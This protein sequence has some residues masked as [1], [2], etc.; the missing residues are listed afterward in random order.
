MLVGGGTWGSLF[1]L[2]DVHVMGHVTAR[3]PSCRYL[4]RAV[5]P[6]SFFLIEHHIYISHQTS[7]Q[8]DK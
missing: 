4:L 2:G 3:G 7:H 5:K 6:L 8:S 1:E